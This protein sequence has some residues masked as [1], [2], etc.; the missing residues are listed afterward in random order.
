MPSVC[1]TPSAANDSFNYT[2]K[3]PAGEST[4]TVT[5]VLIPMAVNDSYPTF[6]TT[7]FVLPDGV[8][9][10]DT[11]NGGAITSYGISATTGLTLLNASAAEEPGV[12]TGVPAVAADSWISPDGKYL[13]TAY[14]GDDKI[15]SYAIGLDGSLAKLGETSVGTAT[16]LSLQG[17]AGV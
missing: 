1:S 10:N 5:L 11:L 14:L 17:L 4:A 6:S 7:L 8:R 3:S 9:S 15:V 16:G 2:L 12:K 13:Y